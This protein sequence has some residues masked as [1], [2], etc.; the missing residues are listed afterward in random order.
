MRGRIVL[1]SALGLCACAG[2]W[3]PIQVGPEMAR[4]TLIRVGTVDAVVE[5]RDPV[6]EGDSVLTGTRSVWNLRGGEGAR[7]SVPLRIPLTAIREAEAAGRVAVAGPLKKAGWVTL[8]VT[9]GGI[10][11]GLIYP[12]P[13]GM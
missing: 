5:V 9:L 1:A 8:G 2:Q 13:A 3:T 10:V 4:H 6:I 7:S 12:L 11:L